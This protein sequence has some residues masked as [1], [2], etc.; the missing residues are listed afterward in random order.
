VTVE[1]F[2]AEIDPSGA[3][4][5]AQAWQGLE[6]AEQARVERF[7]HDSD[8]IRFVAA[9]YLLRYALYRRFGVADA[10]LVAAHGAKPVCLGA[11]L[12]AGLDV[13]LSHGGSVVACALG[14]GV[15][16]GIDVEPLDRRVDAA[17]VA[18]A[19]F[20]PEE[21]GCA[22][23]PAAFLRLWTL[24]EAVAKAAGLGLALELKSFACGSD[25][26]RLL[27]AAPS[28]GLVS[29]WRLWQWQSAAHCMALAVRGGAAFDVGVEWVGW[30]G[31]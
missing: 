23:D 25:P 17:A 13:N 2:L 12:P 5:P 8:R 31:I 4:L 24:K 19:Y 6:A 16:V 14:V 22:E 30:G 9:R 20:A 15:A 18:R 29:D 3:N 11:G 1:V 26:A 10:R 21:Q 7:R 27:H 28:L